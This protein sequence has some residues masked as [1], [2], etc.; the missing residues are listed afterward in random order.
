MKTSKNPAS[1]S[2][3]Q[4]GRS[5]AIGLA[6]IVALAAGVLSIS[7]TRTTVAQSAITAPPT[8]ATGAVPTSAAMPPRQALSAPTDREAELDTWRPTFY[9]PTVMAL[10]AILLAMA[11]NLIIQFQGHAPLRDLWLIGI[12]ATLGLLTFVSA[13]QVIVPKRLY[14]GGAARVF[15]TATF[16]G[17]VLLCRIEAM[18]AVNGIFHI[19][20]AGLPITVLIGTGLT[21]AAKVS[22]PM[23]LFFT[24]LSLCLL[25]VAMSKIS[26]VR[27]IAPR[28][29][30]HRPTIYLQAIVAVLMA[31]LV[32]NA[33]ERLEDK[34]AINQILYRVAHE[35]DFVG[36]FVCP[37]ASSAASK[38]LF[39]GPD[40]RRM[41]VA[42]KI[43]SHEGDTLFSP[44][45]LPKGF[46]VLEC[47]P[48]PL[49]P[50]P[51]ATTTSG[52]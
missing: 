4:A 30:I 17:F 26:W 40:Q 37:P 15:A 48:S 8:P 12:L 14:Q 5:L 20:P 9:Q 21:F 3:D 52:S 38:G 34:K 19:D 31:W 42:P 43:R 13:L 32:L 50:P 36:S 24:L 45:D 28:S 46:E 29:R 44:V 6:T 1:I 16:A 33:D 11:S 49:L 10:A 18:D 47:A 51:Q 7:K 41:L 23:F 2:K 25:A 39:L 35:T 27:G 22:G